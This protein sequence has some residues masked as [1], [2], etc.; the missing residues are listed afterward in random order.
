[1]KVSAT[2]EHGLRCLIH[3]ALAHAQGRTTTIS[4]IASAR[5]MTP[6]YVAKI[7][8]MLRRGGLVRTARGSHGGLRLARPPEQVTVAEAI[9]VLSGGPVRLRPCLDDEHQ[10]DC[11]QEDDCRL[12]DVWK[13]LNTYLQEVLED[14]TLQ[15]LVASQG[16]SGSSRDTGEHHE[17]G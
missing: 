6:A 12:R 1:M 11:G 17:H 5:G 16:A 9:R 10:R 15:S 14:V 7:V 13:S 8:G 2:E 4:E 3:L